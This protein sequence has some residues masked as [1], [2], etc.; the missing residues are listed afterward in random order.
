MFEYRATGARLHRRGS[1]ILQGFFH[2]LTSNIYT[3]G[4]VGS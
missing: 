4:G 2:V 1:Y 3:C